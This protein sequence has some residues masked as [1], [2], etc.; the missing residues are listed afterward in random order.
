MWKKL[1]GWLVK[2]A[3]SIAEAIISAKVK[4]DAQKPKDTS[5]I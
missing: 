3:P 1:L 4:Q 5:G 2:F